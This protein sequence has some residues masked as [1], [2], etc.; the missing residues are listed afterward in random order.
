MQTEAEK[1][2]QQQAHVEAGLQV[3]GSYGPSVS[4]TASLNAGFSS[5]VQETQK[6]STSYSREVTEKT[7]EKVRTKVTEEQRRRVLQQIEES[8]THRIDNTGVGSKHL[9]GIYRWLNK[10]Y[11]AQLYNYG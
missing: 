11:D 1:I 3:S 2:I 6:K 5:S 9:R 7:S 10:I 8:N 4:F